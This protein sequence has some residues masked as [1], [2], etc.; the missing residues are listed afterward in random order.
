MLLC[1]SASGQEMQFSYLE[2]DRRPL[3]DYSQIIY[4]DGELNAGTTDRFIAYLKT[5]PPLGRGALVV[6]NSPGGLVSEGLKLGNAISSLHI[7]TDVGIRSGDTATLPG[8]CMSACLFPYLGGEYRY[9][10]N[11][12][13]IGVHQFRFDS[14]L[15]TAVTSAESQE[16]SGTLVEYIR[17]RRANPVL[18]TLMSRVLPNDIKILSDKELEDNN[19][20]TNDI[21]SENWEF[22]IQN[23]QAYLRGDQ[24]AA[25]GENKF[26]LYCDTTHGKNKAVV[27]A[28]S[29]LPDHKRIIEATRNIIL[30]IDGEERIIPNDLVVFKPNSGQGPWM[31]WGFLLSKESVDAIRRA[32]RVGSGLQ[33]APGI[34]A[35]FLGIRVGE[36]RDKIA[37][38]LDGCPSR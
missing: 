13:K 31:M 21:Y 37:K 2:N 35:G 12:S 30:F 34:F 1:A 5:I 20:V 25:R 38:V 19:V 11:G 29:E 36:G 28:M 27:M 6:L 9:L 23:N 4:G 8:Q 3:F 7:R 32:D 10:V 26:M 14:E 18:F 17:S 22:E 16:L 33:A 15:G 24:V